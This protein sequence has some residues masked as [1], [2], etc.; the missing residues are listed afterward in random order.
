MRLRFSFVFIL[1]FLL[2]PAKAAPHQSD[3]ERDGLKGRVKSIVWKY[4]F[5]KK[6]KPACE[7]QFRFDVQASEY[8]IG[9]KRTNFKSFR[10]GCDAC[11]PYIITYDSDGRPLKERILF[12][13]LWPIITIVHHYNSSQNEIETDYYHSWH[14]A[15]AAKAIY[16]YEFDSHSNWITRTRL[17]QDVKFHNG[18]ASFF[19]TERDYRIIFYYGN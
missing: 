18:D 14:G 9:G 15:P 10:H 2:G 6:E 1:F 8:D 19:L 17:V 12:P 4:C 5:V 11:L 3:L 13:A 7:D 16:K